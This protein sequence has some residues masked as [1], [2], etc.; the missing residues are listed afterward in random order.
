[1][2]SSGISACGVQLHYPVKPPLGVFHCAERNIQPVFNVAG[3][4]PVVPS[5]FKA[6]NVV[7]AA[8]TMNLC[9]KCTCRN[10][11]FAILA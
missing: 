10:T 9:S 7:C 8:T 3:S 2:A 4:N 5:I 1:M 6:N 11:L